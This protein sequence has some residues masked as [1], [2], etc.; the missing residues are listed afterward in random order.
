MRR[1]NEREAADLLQRVSDELGL[2]VYQFFP[3]RK[4]LIP[5]AL[6][7]GIAGACI[8]EFFKG[9]FGLKEM[10]EGSRKKLLELAVRWKERKDFEP[11][12]QTLNLSQVLAE[13][14]GSGDG[15]G[16][17]ERAEQNLRAALIE[18]G[19]SQSMAAAQAKRI[20]QII[21]EGA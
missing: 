12:V 3:D 14:S 8:A 17:H 20:R 19:I 11:Y 7:M 5:E 18:F 16:D 2:E 13:A 4:R 15:P 21:E 6:V 10:G 9:F 1:L